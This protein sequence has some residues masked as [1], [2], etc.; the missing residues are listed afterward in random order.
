MVE[1]IF[2]VSKRMFVRTNNRLKQ[3]LDL[4]EYFFTTFGQQHDFR[5]GGDT[6]NINS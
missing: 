6:V 5:R 3:I 1:R 4:N 2:V